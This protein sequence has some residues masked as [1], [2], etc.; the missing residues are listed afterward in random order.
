M[1][2]DHYLRCRTCC[3]AAMRGDPTRVD[4]EVFKPF[5][6]GLVNHNNTT[7][8]W[9]VEHV[10][11]LAKPIQALAQSFLVLKD[12]EEEVVGSEL[13]GAHWATQL[14]CHL[15]LNEF[16]SGTRI[17]LDFMATHGSHDLVMHSFT[18]AGACWKCWREEKVIRRRHPEHA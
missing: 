5:I 2:D 16:D 17:D 8:P 1:S 4:D 10:L 11:K 18:D 3:T 6:G 7:R 12:A 9:E 14:R 13:T 15:N